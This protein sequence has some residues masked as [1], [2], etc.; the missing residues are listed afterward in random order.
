M[1]VTKIKMEEHIYTG[2]QYCPDCHIE[3]VL[4]DDEDG[5]GYFECPKCLWSVTKQEAEEGL[6]Y[7]TEEAS[8][9][10]IW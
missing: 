5:D 6:G 4:K 7:P 10:E 8:Y 1:S 9:E 3:A 2:H